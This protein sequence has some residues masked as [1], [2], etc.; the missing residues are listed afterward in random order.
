MTN[1]SKKSPEKKDKKDKKDKNKECIELKNIKYKT[2]LLNGNFE[3]S[4]TKENTNI[5][6]FLEKEKALNV[7]EPWNK[8]DKTQKIK[9]INDFA[10]RYCSINGY[11][12]IEKKKLIDF[13]I[14]AIDKKQFTKTKDLTYD[15]LTGVIKNIPNLEFNKKVGK[16][17]LKKTEKNQSVLKNVATLKQT[18]KNKKTPTKDQKDQKEQK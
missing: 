12:N 6:D 8:L 17:H 13:L 16:F 14:Q 9:K 11:N 2:M 4:E 1:D 18:R 7:K 5:E 15:K 3:T 10:E